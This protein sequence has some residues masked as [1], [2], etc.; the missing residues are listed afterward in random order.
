MIKIMKIPEERL[1]VLIGH[2]GTTKDEISGRTRTSIKVGDSVEISGE[3][4]DV[5]LAENI[6]IA[7]ARGFSPENAL[8]L[9]DEENTLEIIDLPKN[10]RVLRRLRSRLIGTGGKCRRNLELLTKTKISIYGKTASIIGSYSSVEL[11]KDGIDRLIKGF[12]H[13][14]V[15]EYLEGKQQELKAEE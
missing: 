14:A 2:N 10:D 1:A 9:I 13:R 11:A 3:S 6:V 4:M 7:I 15:Y 12:S 8:L 5:L